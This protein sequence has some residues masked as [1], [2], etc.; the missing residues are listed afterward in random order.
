MK[1]FPISDSTPMACWTWDLFCRVV[2]NYGDAGVCWRLARELAAR[3]QRVRLWIDEL[4]ALA[5]LW[6]DVLAHDHTQQVEGVNVAPWSLAISA[7]PGDVVIEA[8]A[9]DLPE[10]WAVEMRER[11]RAPVWLNLE[12]LSAEA[13]VA[14]CHALASPQQGLSKY[15]F[16]PGFDAGTGG[17]LGEAGLPERR[18]AWH[19]HEARHWRAA[20]HVPDA[21]LYV[22]IFAYAVPP[23]LVEAWVQGPTTLCCLVPVGRALEQLSALLQLPVP[24]AGE[25]IR[26]GALSVVA[27]PF[28]RQDDYDQ[29]LWS[30]D[31]NLVRGEDSFVRAQWAALPM[32][33]Q[34]YRQDE[35]AH[36]VK[37]EAFLDRYLTGLPAEV[38]ATVRHFWLAYNDAGVLDWPD[39]AASLAA[40]RAHA[41]QW[42]AH[43]HGQGEL[44]SNLV[45]FVR[46]KL[47]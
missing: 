30:C 1:S 2:D 41:G 25:T 10:G 32:V 40:Q 31:L 16:F 8:F 14:G 18:A 7:A 17:L 5:R 6:P 29:L 12:Y 46:G 27:L 42:A 28:L 13:W 38:A 3:G 9:C 21:A 36:L 26:K 33:W 34:I 43:L 20:H 19:Q 4:H 39:F 24:A 45:S 15:F 23:S 35:D 44:V 37:L 22:S 47:E 11:A